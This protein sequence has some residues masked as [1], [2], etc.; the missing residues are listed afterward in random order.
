MPDTNR[1]Q[2]GQAKIEPRDPVPAGSWGTWTI[3][4]TVPAPGIDDGG[5]VRIAVRFASDWAR[6]QTD[7]PASDN[8]VSASSSRED[9]VLQCTWMERGNVRPYMPYL[10]VQV[11]DAPLEKGDEVTVVWG[12]RSGG[13]RGNRAQ[14]FAQDRFDFQVLVDRFGTGLFEPIADHPWLQVV[15]GAPSRLIVFATGDGSL[16]HP[17]RVLVRGE[18]VWGNAATQDIGGVR[19][20]TAGPGT[21][22]PE[23]VDLAG[24]PRIFAPVTCE[25]NG[26][27]TVR[28]E[29]AELGSA[30]G[31][32]LQVRPHTNTYHPFWGDLHGQSEETIGTNSAERYFRYARDQALCDFVAHQGNDFQVTDAFWEEL[33]RLTEEL[34][35][36]GRFVAIPGYEWSGLTPAGGDHN[37]ILA[38]EG[39]DIYRSSTVQVRGEARQAEDTSPV[40]RL[41][42]RLKAAR[43]PAIV[44][45]HI[46]GRRADLDFHDAELE[47]VIEV[48]SCWGTFEWFFHDALRRGYRLGVVANSDG[49]K[50]RP[51]SEHAGA[52]KFGVYGGLTCILAE[53]LDRQSLF[54]ALRARR[55]YGT[56]GP[57]I[58]VEAT[59]AGK[60]IGSELGQFEPSLPLT[61]SVMGTAPIERID[62][63]A[64]GHAV[65]SWEA[66]RYEERPRDRIRIRWSG[67]RILNRNRA[68]RWDGTLRISGD[69]LA[70]VEE[71]AFDTPAHGVQASG[72]S[73]VRWVSSTTGDEDGLVLL[74]DEPAKGALELNTGP[75]SCSV[76]VDDLRSGPIALD[77]G[78]V[79]QE[80]I[81]EFC[82]ASEGLPSCVDWESEVSPSREHA[83]KGLIPYHLR[84]TQVDGHRAWTSP[85]FVKC[86][87]KNPI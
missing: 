1:P 61:V 45:P 2:L 66:D 5:A 79:E 34:T 13:G 23:R 70:K 76:N 38:E 58:H 69:G 11:L 78:G 54:E 75:L 80:V 73:S 39:R 64:A 32:P 52:G 56:S 15:P 7:D 18:D 86:Q 20:A 35:E 4:Y 83:I 16:A 19:I 30:E 24:G 9:V 65:T 3:R 68:T 77:A 22:L 81:F 60:E 63:L 50:G 33:N 59:L 37:V 36:D 72:R 62:L 55:C 10:L 12:D 87:S 46:G 40:T 27:L 26:Q 8:Y 21:D 67:A 47:P 28:A 48:H 31:N 42:S 14:T 82:P 71:F 49:H 25:G 53:R 74:L 51:G 44:F 43:D 6:P 84:I 29:H 17:V 41:Y 57:R 85:W